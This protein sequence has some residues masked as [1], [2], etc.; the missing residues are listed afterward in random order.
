[1]R[2]SLKALLDKVPNS[3]RGMPHLATLEAT[4][5]QEG[6]AALAQASPKTLAK[7]HTQLRVLPLDPADGPI[8]DLLALVRRALKQ[9]AEQQTHQLSP[10]DPQ[11]TVVIVETS[12]SEFM[13]AL[14]QARTIGP[15]AAATPAPQPAPIAQSTPALPP[16]LPLQAAPAPGSAQAAR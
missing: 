1:M 11:S 12:H 14:S 15:Q 10:F 8:Q 16:L 3:R 5:A 9:Q 6:T 7:M 2:Q 4:L 13:D